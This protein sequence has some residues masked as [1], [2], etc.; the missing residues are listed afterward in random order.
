MK[1]PSPDPLAFGDASPSSSPVQIPSP[2][3]K[4]PTIRPSHKPTEKPIAE[5]TLRP[6]APKLASKQDSITVDQDS[7]TV[8]SPQNYCARPGQVQ[9]DCVAGITCN[10]GEG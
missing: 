2:E 6:T 5:P 7:E 8:S 10:D 4:S 9:I 1:S 3:T